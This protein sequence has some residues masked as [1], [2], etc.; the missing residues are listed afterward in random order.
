MKLER[1][2]GSRDKV[3]LQFAE[4]MKGLYAESIEQAKPSPFVGGRKAGLAAL[5]RFSVQVYAG[6]RNKLHGNVSRLSFYIRH[7][8]S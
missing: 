6:T 7:G 3:A 8:I 2:L 1:F 4:A 5:E